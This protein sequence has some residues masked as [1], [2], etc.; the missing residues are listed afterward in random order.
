MIKKKVGIVNYKCGNIKSI[1]NAFLYSGIEAELINSANEVKHAS[2]LVL[3]GV[4]GF[5]YCVENLKSTSILGT[6]EN[7]VF[8]QEK[9]LLGI[10][11][12]MQMMFSSSEEDEGSKGLEWFDGD[13]K[14]LPSSAKHKVP[15]VGWNNVQFRNNHYFSSINE[16]D[17]Y[18]DHSY[19]L[20]L[21]E[22]SSS[23]CFHNH[24]FV[25]SIEHKNILA[26]QFHPEKS[27]KNGLDFLKYFIE[28]FS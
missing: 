7:E 24:K 9:P 12:G 21:S 13:I 22:I 4:G 27:Q 16:L 17:F 10:C 3:P 8:N 14:Q 6:I 11:V 26:S 20:F 19:A 1:L 15:H 18:F 2:H 25:A 23:T 28:N 5:K